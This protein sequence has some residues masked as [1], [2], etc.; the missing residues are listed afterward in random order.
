MSFSI[1]LFPSN[2]KS[3]IVICADKKKK[4]IRTFSKTRTL[5]EDAIDR[6][7]NIIVADKKKKKRASAIGSVDKH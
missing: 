4:T 3:M 1:T 7:V 6:R 5:R 2:G